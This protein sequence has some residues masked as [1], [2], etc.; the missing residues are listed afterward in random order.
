MNWL[1]GKMRI[2]SE[3]SAAARAVASAALGMALLAIAATPAHAETVREQQWHLDAMQAD[4]AWKISKG[5]G[6]TVAVLDSGVDDTIPDLKGQVLEGRDFSELSGDENNDIDNHGTGMASLI[7]GMGGRGPAQGSYG[8]APEAKILPVRIQYSQE[9]MREKSAR[10]T[11]AGSMS[12][13]IRFAADSDA[14]IINISV[15]GN[16]GSAELT[17]AVKYAHDKNKLIFAGVGNG[18]ELGY[19]PQYPASTPGVVGV[20]GLD[21]KASRM[22]VSQ[23][24]PEVDISAP[25]EEITNA[26]TGGTGLCEGS[27]TSAATALASASAALIW[28]KHPDWTNNQVLRVMLNTASGVKGGDRRS[29]QVGYGAVR[30][31]L[32]LTN[33]GDPGPAG[34]YPLPDLKEAA[35]ASPSPNAS[36]AAGDSST[37]EEN[38]AAA[39]ASDEGGGT[40]LWIGLGVGAALLIGGA[41]AVAVVRSRRRAALSSQQP[42]APAFPPY[43]QQPYQHQPYQHQQTN[44]PYPPYDGSPH[45]PGSPPQTPPAHPQGPGS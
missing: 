41:V 26:C 7:A 2:N 30:P 20:G 35:S 19:D 28:S 16:G 45:H 42:T 18:G 44:P 12:E 36:E 23:Y 17:K 13:A 4:E 1:E 34:E 32:A 27:G 38:P 5:R 14:Q 37:D 8:L 22:S 29:D 39:A 40:G 6:V 24:G 10:D 3:R 9:R 31:L 33:P 25:G 11:F 43:Q 21:R 15:A